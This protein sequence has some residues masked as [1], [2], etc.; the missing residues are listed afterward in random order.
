MVKY[1][2]YSLGK[3]FHKVGICLIIV[4]FSLMLSISS[5]ILL[6]VI[7]NV[8]IKKNEDDLNKTTY[9]EKGYQTNEKRKISEKI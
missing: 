1:L 7:L 6:I 5:T 8:V 3:D 2:K 9:K 4:G